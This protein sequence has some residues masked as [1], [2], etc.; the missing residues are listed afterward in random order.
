MRS[1]CRR[2]SNPRRTMTRARRGVKRGK[3]HR[4]AQPTL[5]ERIISADDHMDMNVLPPD[6]FVDGV[7]AS[8]A[9]AV[10]R[11]VPSDD[12]PMWKLGDAVLGPSGRRQRGLITA[13]D[14]GFRPGVAASR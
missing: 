12:G 4:M 14:P 11:V 10:P 7:P 13:G 2:A 9:S 5:P 3:Q 6:L 1:P 8:L